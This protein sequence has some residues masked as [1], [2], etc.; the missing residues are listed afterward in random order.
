LSNGLHLLMEVA[1]SRVR[2]ALAWAM[3]H[4]SGRRIHRRWR[5]ECAALSLCLAACGTGHEASDDLA[6]LLSVSLSER[7]TTVVCKSSSVTEVELER[8]GTVVGHW[9]CPFKQVLEGDRRPSEWQVRDLMSAALARAST[10]LP[11][12]QWVPL[13]GA[14][15]LFRPQVL[16]SLSGGTLRVQVESVAKEKIELT[17]DAAVL[18]IDTTS[19][20]LPARLSWVWI[21][22]GRRFTSKPRDV[23]TMQAQPVGPLIGMAAVR[24]AL[25]GLDRFFGVLGGAPRTS[26]AYAR[27]V[28]LGLE[29]LVAGGRKV[30]D[31]RLADLDGDGLDDIVSNVY[32]DDNSNPADCALIAFNVGGL[33]YEFVR[34]IRSDGSCIGGHGETILVADFDG[35]G[36]TDIFLPSYERFDLLMNLG[37]RRFIEAAGDRGVSY[38]A[39]LPAVE[40]AAVV[41][42]NMDGHID[43]VVASEV[44]INDG[45]GHFKAQF[46][47]FGAERLFDEGLT[48]AD[49]DGDGQFDIVKNHPFDGPR[50]FWGIPGTREFAASDLLLGRSGTLAQSYGLAVA[51]L[52]GNGLADL[53]LSGGTTGGGSPLFCLHGRPREFN[54]VAETLGDLAVRQ[55]LVLTLSDPETG[56]SDLYF[57][58]L[59]PQVYRVRSVARPAVHRFA[60]DLV[61]VS[62][63]R[64]QHGRTLQVSCADGGSRLALRAIDGGN[65]YLSQGG[66]RVELGSD[67]CERILVDVFT[68]RGKIQFGPLEAGLHTLRRP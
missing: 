51:D 26:D 22:D 38:P 52:K 20:A 21:A 63:L 3:V 13:P 59:E 45:T 39:Y 19:G 41:D 18:R 58:T 47:P 60:L 31:L 67:E 12:P 9:K 29:P 54:C 61:D 15:Y 17:V 7:G 36:R 56:L 8:D 10:R 55:D 62:G 23:T 35:D 44:L 33:R 27:F 1:L 64:N 30:R 4:P 25:D 2:W 46:Q 49:L 37:G 5:A 14:L 42:I 34:P 50:I 24:S 28:E 66:Y 6:L 53:V 48:V 43:I 32:A 57:R 11:V 68:P 65:G 40:G 16:D